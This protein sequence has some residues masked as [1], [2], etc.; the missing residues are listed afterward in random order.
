LTSTGHHSSVHPPTTALRWGD[1]STSAR[2]FV[3]WNDDPDFSTTVTLPAGVTAVKSWTGTTI[4]PATVTGG[5]KQ[6]TLSEDAGPVFV[7]VN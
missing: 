1:S 3:M 5:A 4:T 7:F 2:V 6:I